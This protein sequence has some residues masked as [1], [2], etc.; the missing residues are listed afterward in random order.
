MHQVQYRM[1][2]VFVSVTIRIYVSKVV[3]GDRSKRANLRRSMRGVPAPIGLAMEELN[4]EHFPSK[5]GFR[6]GSRR[7]TGPGCGVRR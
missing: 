6:G 4:F 1:V 3:L 2:S 5:N 7:P